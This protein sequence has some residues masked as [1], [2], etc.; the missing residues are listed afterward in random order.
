MTAPETILVADIGATNARFRW[1]G[2]DG[3][4]S[5][6]VYLGTGDYADSEAL[7]ADALAR[8]EPNTPAAAGIA[9]AGAVK[10]GRGQLTNGTL[11]FDAARLR[12]QLGCPIT[13]VNDFF[14]VARS[15]PELRH[16]RQFGGEPSTGR[17]IAGV[18]AAL[19][20]GSGLGMG[21]L[22][23]VG[24]GWRVLPS[25]GGHADLAPGSA[26]EAEILV[27]LQ[28]EHGHVSWETAVSGPGL[29]RL[30]R[31]V[32]HVWGAQPDDLDSEQI[33]S[34][35]VDA[36]DPVCHQ[37]LELFF[38]LLGAAAGNLA[39]TVYARGGVYL[40]G[41]IVPDLADFA[42]ASPMRRRF[43]ERGRMADLVRA[44]PLYLIEDAEPGMTGALACVLDD[45][46]SA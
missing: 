45:A 43:D 19:G 28:A 12:Q 44:I 30:Y 32:C 18:K 2:P 29:V 23:P 33:S 16:L 11:A 37:T 40:A 31:A 6:A 35:G 17:P 14:A 7:V 36:E 9:M 5:A 42:A 27:A 4:A 1:A 10:D 3:L 41:G 22:V 21:V 15:L 24:S 38:S 8:L 39:V 25:E 13:L 20:P 26:L 34:R 46:R